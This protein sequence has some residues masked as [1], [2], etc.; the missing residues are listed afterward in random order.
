MGRPCK[1]HGNYRNTRNKLKKDK[2]TLAEQKANELMK[3]TAKHAHANLFSFREESHNNNCVRL[4]K[5]I[6]DEVLTEVNRLDKKFNL[7]LDGTRIFWY[8]V[9]E[10]LTSKIK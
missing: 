8:E 10:H 7:R 1:R 9:K 2:M 5:I 3:V 4:S 6:C